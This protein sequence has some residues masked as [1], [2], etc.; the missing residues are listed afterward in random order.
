MVRAYRTVSLNAVLLLA[1]ILPLDLRVWEA[2]SLY[3]V[4]RGVTLPELG[5]R[6]VERSAKYATLPHPATNRDYKFTSLT[7]Q[8]EVNRHNDQAVR[9]YTD[10]SKIEGKV[11]AAISIWNDVSETKALKLKLDSHCTVYQAELLAVE[12]ATTLILESQEQ[13][14]GIYSVSRSF[15]EAVIGG[16][17]LHPLVTKIR[18]NLNNCHS[19]NKTV[20]LFW[21]KAHAGLEGNERADKLAKEAALNLKRKPDYDQCPISFVKRQLRIK[22]MEEWNLRY[23][24]GETAA[25]TKVFYPDAI[26]AYREI[27]KLKH[28]ALQ[29][30]ILTGHGGFSKYLHRFKCRT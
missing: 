21:V 16:H 17:S 12:K 11:G 10:G 2:A 30:Q 4:R 23:R 27:R 7:D 22:T 24:S 28:T 29:T 18:G 25:T 13:T 14:F 15:L 26:E 5:D 6:E 20:S 3:E 1:G 9:I 19:Q 8:E